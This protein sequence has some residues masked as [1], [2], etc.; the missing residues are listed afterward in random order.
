MPLHAITTARGEAGVR[1][2]L[3]PEI[4]ERDDAEDRFAA[5][6]HQQTTKIPAIREGDPQCL[7]TGNGIPMARSS[8]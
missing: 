5:I 7:F 3:R 2:R 8:R 6:L 1:Q 4:A